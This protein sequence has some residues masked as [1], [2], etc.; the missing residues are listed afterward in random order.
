MNI[1]RKIELVK[2]WGFRCIN[3]KAGWY[4]REIFDE[5]VEYW[6]EGNAD[7]IE[8]ITPKGRLPDYKI[9]WDLFEGVK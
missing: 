6:K 1:E 7:I 8:F 9:S 4:C 2:E 5:A 3:P